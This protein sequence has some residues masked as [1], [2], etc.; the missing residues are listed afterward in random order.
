MAEVQDQDEHGPVL[1]VTQAR[2][3]LRGRHMAWVLGVSMALIVVAFTALW[4]SSASR[5]AGPGG[6]TTVDSKTAAMGFKALPPQPRPSDSR[7][8]ATPG[9]GADGRGL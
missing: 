5:L 1:T 6:Q 4:L 8:L 3:A 9:I 7:N 2:G